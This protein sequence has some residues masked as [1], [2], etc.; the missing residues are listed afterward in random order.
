MKTLRDLKPRD[1]VFVVHQKRSRY[2]LQQKM[3]TN[4][5]TRIGRLYAYIN[6]D[7]FCRETGRSHHGQDSNARANGYGFDVYVSED[8]YINKQHD[9]AEHE[10]LTAR[11]VDR[12]DGL[13]ELTPKVVAAIHGLLD[14][15]QAEGTK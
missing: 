1:C 11:L 10:R 13:K 2:V 3:E 4:A 12:F 9:A 15:A 6:G 5:I 14:E 8:A 7:Q